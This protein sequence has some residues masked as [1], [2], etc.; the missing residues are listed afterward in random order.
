M[1]SSTVRADLTISVTFVFFFGTGGLPKRSLSDS[2][3]LR[4]TGC[5]FASEVGEAGDWLRFREISGLSS[6]PV[7]V[8]N[9]FEAAFG[10][11]ETVASVPVSTTLGFVVLGLVGFF[12]VSTLLGAAFEGTFGLSCWVAGFSCFCSDLERKLP[13][14]FRRSFLARL[15]IFPTSIFSSSGN[16]CIPLFFVKVANSF[17][18]RATSLLIFNDSVVRGTASKNN[19]T[20]LVD[21]QLCSLMKSSIQVLR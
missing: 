6:V 3:L 12:T 8:I 16:F 18:F 4:F 13:T 9:D 14:H 1:S 10:T 7:S 17:T 19:R 11:E 15:S 20:W 21:F 2:A 5:W